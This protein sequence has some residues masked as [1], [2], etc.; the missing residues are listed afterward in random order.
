MKRSIATGVAAAALLVFATAASA[1]AESFRSEAAPSYVKGSQLTANTFTASFG[2]FN[3]A[4]ANLTGTMAAK[5]TE[6]LTLTPTFSGCAANGQAVTFE[7]GGCTYVLGTPEGKVSQFSLSCP[8]GSVMRMRLPTANC[9][10]LIQPGTNLGTAK[11]TAEG[12]GTKRS[13]VATLNVLFNTTAVGGGLCGS[14]GPMALTGS[15]SLRGYSDAALTKQVGLYV[16]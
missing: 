9:E 4:Q 7:N 3:C 11:L 6:S 8:A 1:S 15:Q 16:G 13:L 2:T 14:S 10:R 12:S 5:S